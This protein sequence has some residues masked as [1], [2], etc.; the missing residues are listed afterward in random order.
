MGRSNCEPAGNV[1]TSQLDTSYSFIF[2]WQAGGCLKTYVS[3]RNLLV[4]TLGVALLP[5]TLPRAEARPE[6][7]LKQKTNCTTC[8]ALPMGAGPRNIAGK[9]FGSRSFAPATSS[10]NDLYYGDFRAEYFRPL[11]GSEDTRNG[12]ALMVAAVSGNIPLKT[13]TTYD[14][15]YVGTFD[16]GSFSTGSREQILLWSKTKGALYLPDHILF[17][18][19]YLPFGLMTDEHRTYTK[20]QS[21]MSFRDY[22]MGLNLSWDFFGSSHLDLALTNGFQSAGQGTNNDVTSAYTGN[23]RL[24]PPGPFLIGTSYSQHESKK[25]AV[26]VA[27]AHSIY[28]GIDFGRL[29]KD[30]LKITITGER[31]TARGWND[32]AVNSNVAFFT[33]NSIYSD[34]IKYAQSEGYYGLFKWDLIDTFT[35]VA[36]YDALAFDSKFPGDRYERRGYGFIWQFDSNLSLLAR[37]ETAHNKRTELGAET[38]KMMQDFWF[39][40]LRGWL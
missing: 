12:L 10:Y 1:L 8:H 5:E 19:F 28:A 23:L 4:L 33:S 22:D 34:S 11:H 39:L 2:L 36:K 16:L 31:V 6:Y 20:M 7:A 14:L 26:T 29:T 38:S 30:W 21:K 3:L 15:K 9:I 32:P 24:N 25:K 35:L 17:G 18:K 27:R 13:G 37:Y 40:M